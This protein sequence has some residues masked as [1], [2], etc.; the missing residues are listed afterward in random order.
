MYSNFDDPNSL[1]CYGNG[2]LPDSQYVLQ[3]LDQL[4]APIG[5]YLSS[6][7]FYRLITDIK[8][9]QNLG[10]CLPDFLQLGEAAVEGEFAPPPSMADDCQPTGEDILGLVKEAASNKQ[11]NPGQS[12]PSIASMNCVNY[13]LKL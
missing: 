8:Q 2:Q 9:V 13:F 10:L 5:K 1:K 3:H 7:K 12:H 4:L 6:D 11:A